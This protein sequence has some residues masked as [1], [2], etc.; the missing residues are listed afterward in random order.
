M[1]LRKDGP[2]VT[3]NGQ[4]VIDAEFD[5]EPGNDPLYER[6]MEIVIA[7]GKASA[8]YIQRRLKVGYNRAARLIEDMER[9]G[10]VSAMQTNGNREVLVPAKA[11]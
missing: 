3:D 10:L 6:A 2:V 7:Q 8:S 4:L 9:A 5:G 1:G 11:E